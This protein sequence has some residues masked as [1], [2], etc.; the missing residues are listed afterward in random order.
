MSLGRND[1]IDTVEGN[2]RAEN[3]SNLVGREFGSEDSPL[4]Q[5]VQRF[6]AESYSGGS[7]SAYDQ[8]NSNSNDRF[9]I[10]GG[11]P[12]TFDGVAVYR[13]TITY[14]DGSTATISAVVFQ[15]TN[16]NTYLAPEIT[17]NSDQAALEAGPIT[18]IT[19]DSLL[20][21]NYSGLA[22]NRTDADFVTCFR[23]GSMILTPDG[24]RL[25]QDLRVGDL[26]VTRDGGAQ[27]I[28]WIGQSECAVTEKTAPICITAG[29][30]GAGRPRRDL[31]VSPQHRMVV[32]SAIAKRV[33]G[34]LEVLVPAKKLTEMP[35][36]YADL[37]EGRVVYFHIL[38]ADHQILF[39]EGAEAESLYLGEMVENALSAEALEE[40]ELLFPDLMS[41]AMVPA[42]DLLDG[43]PGKDLLALHARNRKSLNM[44]H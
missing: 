44:R 31:F 25:V 36:I 8:N 27:G 26:V 38:C 16:G 13:A 28:L 33:A 29:A 4:S 10:D 17:D 35:G 30:M 18:S 1:S 37:S 5:D 6:E 2:S 7:R 11:A 43:R 39:A 24:E 15:D 14:T 19:L 42:R 34:S 23:A 21:S 9:S 22:A 40:L 3:A 32:S 41:A 12:Q 20:G